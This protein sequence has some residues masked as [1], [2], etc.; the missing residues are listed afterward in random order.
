MKY[1]PILALLLAFAWQ[2]NTQA[3]DDQ[4]ENL[5]L[6][7]SPFSSASAKPA[8]KGFELTFSATMPGQGWQLTLDKGGAPQD[9]VINLYMTL[10][11]GENAERRVQVKAATGELTVGNWPVNIH[12]RKPDG[13]YRLR[14]LYIL[15]AGKNG[16]DQSEAGVTAD[17]AYLR[18]GSVLGAERQEGVR[19]VRKGGKFE[20][21]VTLGTPYEDMKIYQDKFEKPDQN[22]VMQAWITCEDRSTGGTGVRPCVCGFGQLNLKL[23]KPKPGTF[24]CDIQYAVYKG[25]GYSLALRA[26]LSTDKPLMPEDSPVTQDGKPVEAA[27]HTPLWQPPKADG[28]WATQARIVRGNLQPSLL[29]P[30]EQNAEWRLSMNHNQVLLPALHVDQQARV[31]ELRLQSGEGQG[32]RVSLPLPQLEAGNWRVELW[33]KEGD[34]YTLD[35]CRELVV[36]GGLRDEFALGSLADAHTRMHLAGADDSRDSL[37]N[38]EGKFSLQSSWLLGAYQGNPK[39]AKVENEDGVIRV[40]VNIPH[41]KSGK[42]EPN[43]EQALK[44]ELGKLRAGHHRVELLVKNGDGE[45]ACQRVIWLEAKP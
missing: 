36:E 9:G 15:R 39:L 26:L 21:Q 24:V 7:L 4:A 14:A 45:Y 2:G 6:I 42:G 1:A 34:R 17:T 37:L 44:A 27:A 25:H 40:K 41:D 28:A 33:L 23:G 20:L 29:R 22:N 32:G 5:Y 8:D 19:V 10:R 13:E 11:R 16:H 12:W 43:R 38:D 30:D 31:L 18:D 35:C 3:Q